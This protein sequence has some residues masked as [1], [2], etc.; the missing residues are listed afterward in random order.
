MKSSTQIDGYAS[1]IHMDPDD[2]EDRIV[3]VFYDGLDATH[4]IRMTSERAEMVVTELQQRIE[5]VEQ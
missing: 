2:G 5:Q 3:L 1:G 4:Q